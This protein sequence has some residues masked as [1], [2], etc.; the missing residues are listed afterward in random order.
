M[1]I[2]RQL[3]RK[4]YDINP[5]LPYLLPQCRTIENA[6]NELRW[7]KD[8]FISKP[9][10]QLK[11]AC[12]K[13]YNGMP[14][15]YILGT[16][17]FGKDLNILCK[18]NVL[19]PRWETDEICSF[20]NEIFLKKRLEGVHKPKT[21]IID[22]CTGS[23][24]ISASIKEAYSNVSNMF[25]YGVDVSEP[26]IKLSKENQEYNKLDNDF[27]NNKTWLGYVLHDV[28]NPKNDLLNRLKNK[29]EW[30]GRDISDSSNTPFIECII[31]NPPYIAKSQ[32]PELNV[33]VKKYEP[34]KALFGELQFYK[35]FVNVWSQ[36]CNSF[37]Y[38]LGDESQYEC[39]KAGLDDKQ[40]IVK[41]W[42]DG[43][44]KLRG[45]YGY[46]KSLKGDYEYYIK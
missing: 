4:A 19:I 10:A 17:P 23:G 20:V 8:Y 25:V 7:L 39:I 6:S 42:I 5:L 18:K 1:R 3:I 37:F 43:N 22:L 32:L 44:D 2:N 30:T 16:Q 27:E 29:N 46:R 9:P 12:I 26:C 35:N 34:H 28:L 13:R 14:L 31:S 11:K 40:W 38:E 33:S 36:H 24:C 21:V 15:Q 45:V 41:K